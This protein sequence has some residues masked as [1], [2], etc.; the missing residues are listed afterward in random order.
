[1]LPRFTGVGS[2]LCLSHVTF[3]S[4][5]SQPLGL[6]L[7]RFARYL[8]RPTRFLGLRHEPAGSSQ[9]PAESD[10][11][12]YGLTFRFQLLPTPPRSDAVTF[13]YKGDNLL[14]HGLAPC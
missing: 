2:S 8:Q 3:L 13:S 14:W 11:F 1:M 5:R 9:Y 7:G 12:S 10:S 6:P 4:F